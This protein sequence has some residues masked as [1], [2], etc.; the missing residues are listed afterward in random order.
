M[1]KSRRAQLS[2]GPYPSYRFDYDFFAIT[3]KNAQ[4]KTRVAV[5]V[6]ELR[7]RFF[8]V[9]LKIAFWIESGERAMRGAGPSEAPSTTFLKG[10]VRTQANRAFRIGQR[11]F[12]KT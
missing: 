5:L 8:F 7:K 2:F 12:N 3:V 10:W 4:I 11:D 6:E 1:L 9:R